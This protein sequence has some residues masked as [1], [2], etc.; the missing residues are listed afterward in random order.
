MQET[1]NLTLNQIRFVEAY[2]RTWNPTLAA[3]EAGYSGTPQAIHAS[4]YHNLKHP[5]IKKMVEEAIA[6]KVMGASEVLARLSQQARAN[7]AEFLDEDGFVSMDAVRDRGYL[8]KKARIWEDAAGRLHTEI[9]MYDSQAA[10]TLIARHLGLF[11]DKIKIVD[12]RAEAEAIGINDGELFNTLVGA[13][14]AS[15]EE[16]SRTVDAGGPPRIAAQIE[17]RAPTV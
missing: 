14:T 4:A 13:V 5:Q 16:R 11:E 12:W 3:K 6:E 1:Q 17:E 2:L 10:L 8:V 9:E 7:I 15:I